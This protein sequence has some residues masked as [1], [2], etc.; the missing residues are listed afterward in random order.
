M[1]ISSRNYSKS[2]K[3]QGFGLK[4]WKRFFICFTCLKASLAIHF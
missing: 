2:Q 3:P 1:K 4:L